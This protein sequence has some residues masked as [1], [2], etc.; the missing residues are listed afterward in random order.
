MERW[1]AQELVSL[2]PRPRTTEHGSRSA[3]VSPSSRFTHTFGCCTDLLELAVDRARRHIFWAAPGEKGSL[4]LPHLRV[5]APDGQGSSPPER[6]ACSRDPTSRDPLPAFVELRL[7]VSAQQPTPLQLGVDESYELDLRGTSGVLRATTEW[8]ALRGLESFAQLVQWTGSDYQIC[9]LPLLIRDS[10][11]WKWRGMLLDTARHFL[12]LETAILPMLNAMEALKLN[13][14]HLHLT[15]AHS[16]PFG[17]AAL[18]ELPAHGAMHPRLVYSLDD[19]RWLVEQARLR[20]IRVVPELD[21]PAHTAAWGHGRPDL[22]IACPRRVLE[23][24]EGA[25][26]GLNKV[27][28]HPLLEATYEA[29]ES[30]LRE[31][32]DVFPDEYVHLGGDE[33]DGE[34]W[35]T[36]PDVRKWAGDWARQANRHGTSWKEQLQGTFTQRVA[37]MA[38]RHGKRVILWDDAMEAVAA[39]GM[40]PASL[41]IAVWRDWVKRYHERRDQALLLGHDVIWASLNWYQDLPGNTWDVM[42]KAETMPKSFLGGQT[43]SWH[44]HGDAFNLQQRTIIR[45]AAVAERL[46]SAGSFI[47]DCYR[48]L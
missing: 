7:E 25:E 47:A 18:P 46:W 11:E 3:V 15:D 35:L 31:M 23:D 6:R 21:M 27:A 8:G 38:Q 19:L 10:P 24:E 44:E 5:R 34:C 20:G 45:A 48:V 1:T 32:A 4:P 13:V 28:L 22:T 30:L 40:K 2:W 33:V 37:R 16:F 17:S 29:I 39:V 14:L 43:C 42:Y 9:G 41:T 26:H 12:P 36:H